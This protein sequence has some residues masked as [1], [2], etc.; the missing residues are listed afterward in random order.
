MLQYSEISMKTDLITNISGPMPPL[1]GGAHIA[2][3]NSLPLLFVSPI[4][5]R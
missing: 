3:M 1:A 4:Y 2:R 5:M